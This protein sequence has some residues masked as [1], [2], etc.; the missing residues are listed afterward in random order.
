DPEGEIVSVENSSLDLCRGYRAAFGGGGVSSGDC[1]GVG[2]SRCGCE[3]GEEYAEEWAA[4]L[5]GGW[6]Y[7]RAGVERETTGG[8]DPVFAGA[9]CQHA[10]ARHEWRDAAASGSS[11]ALCGRGEGFARS[12]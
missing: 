7:Y 3:C 12:R 10:P 4:A 9:W 5:C 11:H 6:V 2:Q 8:D 1:E